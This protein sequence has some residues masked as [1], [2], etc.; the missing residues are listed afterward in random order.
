MSDAAKSPLAA[1]ECAA[2]SP[3][4]PVVLSERHAHLTREIMEQLFFDEHW[5]SGLPARPDSRGAP[6]QALSDR[7]TLVGPRG[8]LAQVR[9]VGPPRAECQVELSQ[10]DARMLGI[11]APL[12]ESG[13][14]KDTPGVFVEG[15]RACVRL[16][17]GVIR[18][19]RHVHLDPAGAD[20]FGLRDGD[21]IDVEPAVGPPRTL[22]CDVLVRVSAAF[23][24]QLHLD[25]EEGLAAGLHNGSLVMV[26]PVPSLPAR[27]RL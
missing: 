5:T 2:T 19:L 16:E 15:P 26:K 21:H 13:N 7:V 10:S 27:P 22:F 20:R 24:P 18:T 8:R 12:R 14:L 1:S 23:E 9:V 4:I 25:A 11:H 17:H 6:L 3:Q